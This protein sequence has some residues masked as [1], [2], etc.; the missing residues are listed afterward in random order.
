M[1]KQNAIDK[2][3]CFPNWNLDD[4]WLLENEMQELSEMAIAAL[5]RQIPRKPQIEPNK[6]SSL[7]QH[8]YCPTCGRYFGQRGIHNE[9]LFSK[10]SYCQGKGCGQAM[11]WSE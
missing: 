3:K 10:E 7:T 9:I 2:I 8:C 1:T 5:E 6:Y 11:D 4:E